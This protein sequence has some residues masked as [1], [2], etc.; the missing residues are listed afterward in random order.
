MKHVRAYCWKS[1]TVFRWERPFFAPSCR[2]HQWPDRLEIWKELLRHRG[3]VKGQKW[4]QHPIWGRL[5]KW[6]K[7]RGLFYYYYYFLGLSQSR[8][9]TKLSITYGRFAYQ[10]TCWGGRMCLC[11]FGWPRPIW[12][13]IGAEN[14]PNL[15]RDRDFH[16][17]AK[18]SYLG[19]GKA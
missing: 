9:Q 7:Y 10:M 11:K 12:G 17:K 18:M 15:P 3:M 4:S 16:Y 6:V 14:P 2:L 5:G 1:N 13:Q 8:A 19:N